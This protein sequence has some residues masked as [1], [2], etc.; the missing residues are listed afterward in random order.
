MEYQIKNPE[1]AA[2][3][4][5]AILTRWSRPK[6]PEI[7]QSSRNA[8]VKVARNLFFFIEKIASRSMLENADRMKPRQME[9][10]DCVPVGKMPMRM[11]KMNADTR[12]LIETRSGFGNL[13]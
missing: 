7:E 1:I 9:L 10:W 11:R 13:R 3:S 12:K 6:I 5:N 2:S 4:A 8:V